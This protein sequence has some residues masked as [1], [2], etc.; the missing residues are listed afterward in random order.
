MLV[1]STT[2]PQLFYSFGPWDRLAHVH[3]M[4]E[5]PEAQAAIR[6]VI[7]LRTEATPGSYRVVAAVS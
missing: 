6:S 4:R 2:D 7:D 3:D 1:Q 5:N